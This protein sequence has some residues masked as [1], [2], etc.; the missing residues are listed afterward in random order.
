[1]S[2]IAGTTPIP[3]EMAVFINE[4]AHQWIAILRQVRSLLFVVGCLVCVCGCEGAKRY[5][6]SRVEPEL[7]RRIEVLEQENVRLKSENERYQN[8]DM[9]GTILAV[10][11][12][13]GA[14][15]GGICIGRAIECS[16][17]E[18]SMPTESD[19]TSAEIGNCVQ[20]HTEPMS[21][22]SII[23]EQLKAQG[24]GGEWLQLSAVVVPATDHCN[25]ER[26]DAS[27]IT[28]RCVYVV[29]CGGDEM[30]NNNQEDELCFLL[31]DEM[32]EI[33]RETLSSLF[34]RQASY[35][36]QGVFFAYGDMRCQPTGMGYGAPSYHFDHSQWV[37][38][39]SWARQNQTKAM[40][41]RAAAERPR[42]PRKLKTKPTPSLKA[43]VLR[44]NRDFHAQREDVKKRL[45]DE[46]ALRTVLE[47]MELQHKEALQ[48]LYERYFA[49]QE[50][51][52]ERPDLSAG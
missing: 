11:L 41:E 43:Q 27:T 40:R 5:V 38:L 42:K 25:E 1:M 29:Y 34:A 48:K 26:E 14:L 15:V 44:L 10:V 2:A 7:T 50:K 35:N 33:G 9:L 8:E 31:A 47:E 28:K 13:I 39:V 36:H 16:L 18:G 19:R 3:L 6:A 46:E 20:K 21:T 52:D 49:Q 51:S 4:A 24:F 37:K 32:L 17:Q 23:Q 22:P 45:K 30:R 12:V